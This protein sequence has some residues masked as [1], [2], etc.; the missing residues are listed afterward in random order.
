MDGRELINFDKYES[1]EITSL[2]EKKYNTTNK[3]NE[4]IGVWDM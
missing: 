4:K 2:H 3:H 1:Y